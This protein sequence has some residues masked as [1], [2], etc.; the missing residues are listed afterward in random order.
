MTLKYFKVDSPTVP[1]SGE[2]TV[3]SALKNAKVR[4]RVEYRELKDYTLLQTKDLTGTHKQKR[5]RENSVFEIVDVNYTDETKDTQTTRKN[6]PAVPG[7]NMPPSPSVQWTGN[8]YIRIHSLAIIN[9]L[10][11]V[12]SY[13]P[14]KSVDGDP[15]DI[16]APYAILVHHWELLEE[17]RERFNSESE[18][19]AA[20]NCEV[21]DTY[22]HL[23]ILL[24]FLESKVGEN[25]RKERKRWSEPVPKVSF[26]MLW[27]LLK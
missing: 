17:F 14:Y 3:Q 2:T 18:T 27:L 20:V 19:K 26:D 23:G 21:S 15:V 13:Y 9:A 8:Q 16:Y 7:T 25:V 24:D 4:Y 22:E 10:R 5:A 1:K 6:D 11:S 12:I